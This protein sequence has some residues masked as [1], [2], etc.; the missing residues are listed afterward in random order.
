MKLSTVL[1][2]PGAEEHVKNRA[3]MKLEGLYAR[4]RDLELIS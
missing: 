3:E 1:G 4:I 2:G